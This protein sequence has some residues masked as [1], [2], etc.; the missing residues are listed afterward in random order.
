MGSRTDYIQVWISRCSRRPCHLSQAQGVAQLRVGFDCGDLERS[1]QIRSIEPPSCRATAALACRVSRSFI[2]RSLWLAAVAV[3]ARA[4][5]QDSSRL[6]HMTAVAGR[7]HHPIDASRRAIVLPKP[8]S[9][10]Y[11]KLPENTALS[12]FTTMA[13]RPSPPRTRLPLPPPRCTPLPSSC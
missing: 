5:N 7:L 10:G 3:S 11:V 12:P 2:A 13:P 8:S 1:W 9:R 4:A 6:W